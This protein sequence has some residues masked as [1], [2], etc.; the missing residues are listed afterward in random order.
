[1][2][3]ISHQSLRNDHLNTYV[4]YFNN[5][6]E[7]GCKPYLIRM[8]CFITI[9]STPE[10]SKNCVDIEVVETE[11]RHKQRMG[12]LLLIPSGL[13]RMASLLGHLKI[14]TVSCSIGFLFLFAC[15]FSCFAG[16]LIFFS[17]SKF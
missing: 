5:G 17:F 16:F 7:C 6:H 11:L 2:I 12:F 14:H 13:E 9:P 3:S 4:C 10:K 1:M 15:F 8:L